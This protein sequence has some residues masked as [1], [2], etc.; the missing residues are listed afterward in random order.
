[1]PRRREPERPHVDPP[2]K[3]APLAEKK[4]AGRPR[5]LG[6]SEKAKII[7]KLERGCSIKDSAESVGVSR[8]TIGDERN[9]DPDFAARVIQAIAEGKSVLIERIHAASKEDWRAAA[10]M[11]ERR[12]GRE[13]GRRDRYEH[14]GLPEP[15]PVPEEIKVS[16][17]HR[18]EF[19]FT[20]LAQQFAD[21]AQQS[22]LRDQRARA[23]ENNGN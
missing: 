1:M 17:E 4:K 15:Q 5:K 9:R 3:A 14:R 22:A 21:Y 8:D 2:I 12:F 20:Q 16:V 18:H 10:F 7:K 13:W 19:D 6:P 11:L 23:L